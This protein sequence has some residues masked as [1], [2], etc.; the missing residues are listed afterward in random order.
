MK[1]WVGHF[2]P[3]AI[4][5][6]ILLLTATTTA[7]SQTEP[8]M[9]KD[10]NPGAGY[11]D[12]K[13]LIKVNGT[14]FFVANDGVNGEELWKSDGTEAG[15]VMVRDINLGP[16]NS[17]PQYLVQTSIPSTTHATISNCSPIQL[18]YERIPPLCLLCCHLICPV[19]NTHR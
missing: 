17:E 10:I 13:Y 4:V 11:S 15:T 16:G 6:A 19:L 5:L 9:V 12:P 7:M 2:P 14:L 8:T 1:S 18:F 3:A